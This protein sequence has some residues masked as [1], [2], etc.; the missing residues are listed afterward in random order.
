[1][2]LPSEAALANA[3]LAV[4]LGIILFNVLGLVVIPIGGWLD[5]SFVRRPWWRLLHLASWTIVALQALVGRAC[6]L[7]IWQDDLLGADTESMPLV[8]R[9][10]DRIVYWPLPLWLF[11]A[12][13][14][15]AFV[16]V[17]AMLWLVPP[18]WSSIR[19][20]NAVQS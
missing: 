13:Y 5:W 20:R 11:A 4:H 15:A 10:V 17:L 9:W 14:V 7:T 18:R 3:V 6:F 1:M 19:K 2:P 16:A 12:L 8:M